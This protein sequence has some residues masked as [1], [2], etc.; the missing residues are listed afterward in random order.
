MHWSESPSNRFGLEMGNEVH[1]DYN[2]PHDSSQPGS[3][4]TVDGKFFPAELQ[5]MGYNAELFSNLSEASR[6]PNGVVGVSLMVQETDAPRDVSR[7]ASAIIQAAKKVITTTRQYRQL[8][9]VRPRRSFEADCRDDNKA[10][11]FLFFFVA[12]LCQALVSL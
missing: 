5:I 12:F 4:H 2:L 9:S 1:G 3:E 8:R 11:R 10:I 7:V 6:H